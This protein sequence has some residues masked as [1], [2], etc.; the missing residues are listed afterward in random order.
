MAD[1][2]ILIDVNVPLTVNRDAIVPHGKHCAGNNVVYL[3]R[4]RRHA[5]IVNPRESA[6]CVLATEPC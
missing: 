2:E 3:T 5:L 4:S 1:Q 6:P